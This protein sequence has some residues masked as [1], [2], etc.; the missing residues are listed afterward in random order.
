MDAKIRKN[1]V[2]AKAIIKEAYDEGARLFEGGVY[3]SYKMKLTMEILDHPE[4]PY[5]VTGIHWVS[6]FYIHRL[7]S[8]QPIPVKVD[9]SDPSRV[10]LDLVK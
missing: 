5:T 3:K 9:K 4:S 10:A 7:T 2:D 6:E 8:G 1:G